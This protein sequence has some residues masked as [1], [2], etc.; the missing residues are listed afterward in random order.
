MTGND[1]GDSLLYQKL[2]EYRLEALLG[3]GG[4]AR[5]YRGFDE[6]LQR[7]VA[8]KVIDA[9]FRGDA[10]YI[11]RFEREARAIAQ[12]KH[13]HI[14]GVY[15]YGEAEG[16]LYLAME[17]IEGANLAVV[18]AGYRRDQKLMPF[19]EI[20]RIIRPICLALDYA[21]D[22][23]VI[24]RDVT[25]ANI[26]LDLDGRPILTDFGLA[27]LDYKTRGEIFGTPQYMA[28]EQVVSSAKVVPQSD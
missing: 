5:V 24:H 18:L 25:P 11:S 20:G 26:M 15:R 14:V 7:K 2:D 1:S 12:L 4:M 22:Q 23:G 6:R 17:Y 8:I 21:H 27:L 16:L 19:S 10:D 9:P 13:P 3:Q 28:P